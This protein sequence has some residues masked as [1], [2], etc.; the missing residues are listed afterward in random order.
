MW[1][2][3]NSCA[4]KIMPEVAYAYGLKAAIDNEYLKQPEFLSYTGKIKSEDFVREAL[5]HFWENQNEHR[6]EGMLPK[7]AFFASRIEELQ[8]ELRPAVEQVL[9]E[10]GIPACGRVPGRGVG[11]GGA[12]VSCG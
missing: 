1:S 10:L 8:N 12:S 5:T 11:V 6:R 9:S 4:E 7:I 2:K 3:A